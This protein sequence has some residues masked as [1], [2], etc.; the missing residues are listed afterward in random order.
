DGDKSFG[1]IASPRL[2]NEAIFAMKR[3]AKE[4]QTD[5]FAIADRQN[6]APIFA[7]L[8]APLATHHD[9]RHAATII[10]IGGEPEEE[11][12]YTAKQVRQAVRNDGAKLIVFNE[13]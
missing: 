3:F 12:T 4:A 9:I 8:S 7:N 13:R 1:V 2:T 10:I 11:Q 6:F 5:N